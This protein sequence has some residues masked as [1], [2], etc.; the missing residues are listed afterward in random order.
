MLDIMIELHQ[1]ARQFRLCPFEI[2]MLID[3]RPLLFEIE[4]NWVTNY[5][6]QNQAQTEVITVV[7]HKLSRQIANDR[8]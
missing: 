4:R 8:Y 3:E 2:F 6:T 7:N 5:I 1:R